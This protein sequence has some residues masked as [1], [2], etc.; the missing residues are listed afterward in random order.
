MTLT[1]TSLPSAAVAGFSSLPSDGKWVVALSGGRDSIALLDMA[2]LWLRE[3]PG[4]VLCA[5][6]VDHGLQPLS[7]DWRRFC[8]D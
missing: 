7:A 4:P 6:H 1:S 2:Q 5:V 8:E 3:H